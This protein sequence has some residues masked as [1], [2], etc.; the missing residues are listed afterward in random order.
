MEEKGSFATRL[1]ALMKKNKVTTTKLSKATSISE[2]T[3][4][5]L[6][7]GK[8]DNPTISTATA[9]AKY[10]S[11]S[12]DY[13]VN[14]STLSSSPTINITDI[15]NFG[16]TYTPLKKDDI[17]KDADFAVKITNKNY[18]LYQN[19]SILLIKITTQFKNEDIILTK[20]NNQYILCKLI[21]EGGMY[22]GKSLTISDKYYDIT[23]TQD[24]LGIVIGVIWKK[25]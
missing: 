5:K 17:F 19:N 8:N 21:I 1:V 23:E 9:L 24:I 25:S 12:I 4:N 18:P 6:R 15:D 14:D 22:I 3:I 11:V 2:I 10:F 13:L 20:V 7:N 16:A